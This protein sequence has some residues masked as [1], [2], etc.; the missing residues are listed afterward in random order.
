[1]YVC[2]VC[3]AYREE[4]EIAEYL[5]RVQ[6]RQYLE[7][8][9][10]NPNNTHTANNYVSTRSPKR[11]KHTTKQHHKHGRKHK[12]THRYQQQLHDWPEEQMSNNNNNNYNNTNDNRNR[13]NVHVQKNDLNNNGLWAS[14]TRN[15]SHRVRVELS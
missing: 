2:M 6:Q 5:A 12:H 7:K 11:K 9:N 3:T 14:Y 8:S 10:A 4:A 13:H 1:M 15:Q